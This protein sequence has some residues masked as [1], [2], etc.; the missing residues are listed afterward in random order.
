MSELRLCKDSKAF[1]SLAVYMLRRQRLRI[2]FFFNACIALFV[3]SI[4]IS[5][6]NASQRMRFKMNY[7]EQYSIDE[8]IVLDKY[9]KDFQSFA[10][11]KNKYWPFGVSTS[12]GGRD[13]EFPHSSVLEEPLSVPLSSGWMVSKRVR[14]WDLNLLRRV[15][16]LES[17][18]FSHCFRVRFNYY[19]YFVGCFCTYIYQ[20]RWG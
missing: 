9:L 19:N 8:R 4:Q 10:W 14:K 17:S 18:Y 11:T 13:Q 3:S 7:K 5:R 20:N 1:Q 6:F 16:I 15:V 2:P 12:Y